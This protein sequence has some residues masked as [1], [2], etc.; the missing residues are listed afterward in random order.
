MA[1]FIAMKETKR[2][3]RS[4]GTVQV[5]LQTSHADDWRTFVVVVPA[6]T[7]EDDIKA[8]ATAE[9]QMRFEEL[10]EAHQRSLDRY[11]PHG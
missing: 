1:K 3:V 7:D 2:H 6:N 9:W 11:R 4:D 8:Q 5:T 10:H